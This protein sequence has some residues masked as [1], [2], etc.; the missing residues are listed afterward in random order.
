MDPRVPYIDAFARQEPLLADEPDVVRQA[1]RRAFERFATLDFPTAK[2][3]AWRFTSLAPLLGGA[4][5]PALAPGGEAARSAAV[6]LA[7]T[8]ATAFGEGLRLVF[9]DGHFAPRLSTPLA[10]RAGLV[11]A[12]LRAALA[13]LPDVVGPSLQRD[14]DGDRPFA[15]LNAALT[16][17]GALLRVPRGHVLDDPV[18]LV[19]VT[20]GD[21]VAH[22]RAIIALEEES[23]A[24]VVETHLHLGAG[25]AFTNAVI[26]V[27][28][29]AGAAL[30][31][32]RLAGGDDLHVGRAAYR[33]GRD[34]RLG[35]LTLARGGPLQRHEVGVVLDAGATA[36]LAGLSLADGHQQVDHHLLVDHAAPGGHSRAL[37]KGVLDGHAHAVFDGAVL[38]RPGAQ[39]TDAVLANHNLLLSDDATVNSKPQFNIHADDVKCTHAATV[40]Q[41]RAEEIFYL[42]SRGLGLEAA[43]AL[44]LQA[45]ASEILGPVPQ[46]PLRAA[47][48]QRVLEWLPGRAALAAAA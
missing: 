18:S 17:D 26:D 42:R 44:L 2:D 9:V 45:F 38:V 15:A 6:T 1:R 14:A 5:V 8:Q 7:V 22:P 31:H 46:G 47:L 29:G 19:F 10:S 39:Q 24:A 35:A 48:Q 25:A 3:E 32:Y 40:G 34:A 33:V 30:D 16:R 11:V 4:F 27:S 37:Y 28:L 41:L 13:Q 36:T 23:R 20:T 21:H 43:R 12:P